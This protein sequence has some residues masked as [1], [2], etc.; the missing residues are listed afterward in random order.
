MK[1]P[2]GNW[3]KEVGKRTGVGTNGLCGEYM[4]S[5]YEA[6]GVY[7]L[8]PG[9]FL[10]N[11]I[12]EVKERIV[13]IVRNNRIIE[14]QGG[15]QAE[16]FKQMLEETGNFMAFNLAEFAIGLNPGKP[17][18]VHRSVVAEKL[19]G[20]IHIAAGTNS[21]CLS[22]Y[23]PELEKFQHGRY[24]CGVHVDCIKFNSSVFFQADGQ[25]EWI[26]L[27]VKGEMI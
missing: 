11:P 4:T 25:D 14:I 27:L 22:E 16:L 3:I 17:E 15:A 24:T 18:R 5:P 9:D 7:V 19:V 2:S 10:T 23:C 20:G 1:V 21:L 6:N 26:T 12:N 8:N 13:L